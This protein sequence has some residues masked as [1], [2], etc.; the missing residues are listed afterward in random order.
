MMNDTELRDSFASSALAGIIQGGHIGQWAATFRRKPTAQEAD[1]MDVA[2]MAAFEAY[3]FA[4]AMM[5][6][7]GADRSIPSP[8]LDKLLPKS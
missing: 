6:E 3:V 4:D 1:S 8:G 5:A 7:R 2:G